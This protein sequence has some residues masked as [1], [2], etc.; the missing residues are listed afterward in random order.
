MKKFNQASM[1][2]ILSERDKL[3]KKLKELEATLKQK[4]A[5]IKTL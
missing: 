4:D 1:K 3:N 5:E 2:P